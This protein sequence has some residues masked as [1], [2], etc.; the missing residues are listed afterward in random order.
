MAEWYRA[1]ATGSVDLGFDSE[2]GQ[3]NDLKFGI[4]SFPAWGSAVKRQCGKQA[5]KFTCCAV[6]KDT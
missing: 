2:S 1:S 4:H 6:K 5:D 3:T